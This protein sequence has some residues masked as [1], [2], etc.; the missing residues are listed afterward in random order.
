MGFKLN[1]KVIGDLPEWM[2]DRNRPSISIEEHERLIGLYKSHLMKQLGS[3]EKKLKRKINR[4]EKQLL[5][6]KNN[7]EEQVE[8][9]IINA[10]GRFK[11]EKEKLENNNKVLLASKEGLKLQLKFL[12]DKDSYSLNEQELMFLLHFIKEAN[13]QGAQLEHIFQVTLKLQDQY[14]FLKDN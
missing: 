11:A 6:A 5:K 4:I 12:R 14:K 3:E 8:K 1:T 9:N 10:K 2:V 13:F 7:V